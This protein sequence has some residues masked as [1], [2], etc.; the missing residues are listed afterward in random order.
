MKPLILV[1]GASG[2]IGGELRKAL[3][4]A[5]QRVRCLV[6]K[7]EI[8]CSSESAQEEVVSGDLLDRSSVQAALAA[9]YGPKTRTG[10]FLAAAWRYRC[11]SGRLLDQGSRDWSS[12]ALTRSQLKA[13]FGAPSP[14]MPE[15]S[16][17]RSLNLSVSGSRSVVVF[18]HPS[19]AL[20]AADRTTISQVLP[21]RVDDP[22]A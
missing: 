14:L 18:Q 5:N 17:L 20:T 13:C 2:Y 11:R 7:P 8:L 6:R 3:L 1:T 21:V 19:E 12:K 10:H 9:A 16:I 15:S 4:G 22:I